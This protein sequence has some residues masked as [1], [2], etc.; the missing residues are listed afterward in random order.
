LVMLNDPQIVEASRVLAY[1]CIEKENDP[2]ER[3]GMMF[4]LATS[5]EINSDELNNLLTFFKEEKSKFEKTP[6]DAEALLQIGEYPQRDLLADP[7]MAAYTII[8]NVI[9]NLDET[10]TKG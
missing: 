5:R 8:A 7:A 1:Q 2:G 10:I 4:R 9:F 6:K 3:I